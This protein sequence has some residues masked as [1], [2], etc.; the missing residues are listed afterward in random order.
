MVSQSRACITYP[1]HPGGIEDTLY[2]LVLILF[3]HDSGSISLLD[4]LT[5]TL[6]VYLAGRHVVRV[7]SRAEARGATYGPEVRVHAPIWRDRNVISQDNECSA[8]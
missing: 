6:T 5:S 1:P 7:R 4:Y 2:L 8:T 3:M